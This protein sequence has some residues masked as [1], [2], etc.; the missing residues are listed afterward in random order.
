M[1]VVLPRYTRGL[2]RIAYIALLIT[3]SVHWLHRRNHLRA[4]TTWT[5][6]SLERAAHQ[7]RSRHRLSAAASWFWCTLLAFTRQLVTNR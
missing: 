2:V 6:P 1:L 4:T 7:S 5:A 3:G